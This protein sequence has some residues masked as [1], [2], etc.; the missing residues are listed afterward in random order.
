MH[1]PPPKS[2]VVLV[3]VGKRNHVRKWSSA[4]RRRALDGKVNGG[5]GERERELLFL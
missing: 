5:G 2:E 4:G 3:V 1:E